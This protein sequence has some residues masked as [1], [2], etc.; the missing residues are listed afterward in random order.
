MA[1]LTLALLLPVFPRFVLDFI[2][3]AGGH[4]LAVL[5]ATALCL[6]SRLLQ[7]QSSSSRRDS[8]YCSGGSAHWIKSK[9]VAFRTARGR[10]ADSSPLHSIRSWPIGLR[11]ASR[12]WLLP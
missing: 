11:E 5:T 12:I 2:G 10:A 8:V 7:S 3:L 1:R 4:S 6:P 9:N